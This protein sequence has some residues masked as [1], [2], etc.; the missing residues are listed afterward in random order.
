[1]TA[2]LLALFAFG[3]VMT[4]VV[5]IG[6]VRAREIAER[7]AQVKAAESQQSQR[8]NDQSHHLRKVP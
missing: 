4:G 6:I 3:L 2:Q 1:M 5:Y 8:N 7:T